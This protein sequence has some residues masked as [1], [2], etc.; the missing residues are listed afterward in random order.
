MKNIVPKENCLTEAQL[1]RYLR[2]ECSA[3][4]VRAIDRHLTHCPMCSDALEGA[5]LLSA[6]RLERSLKHL[7]TKISM[8]FSEKTP[9]VDAQKPV[10]TVVKSP[11][12][13]GWL[14]AAASIAV[15]V[16]AGVMLLTK[17]VE[18][19]FGSSVVVNNDTV[20][21]YQSESPQVSAAAPQSDVAQVG[22]SEK[23][24]K[25]GID[26]A[27]S[28]GKSPVSIENNVAVTEKSDARVAAEQS[29]LPNATTT[30]L[31]QADE[32]LAA[33]K[34][35]AT[36]P[37]N[38]D[39][40][41]ESISAKEAIENQRM[42]TKESATKMQDVAVAD[43]Y[44]K[45][46]NNK[47]KQ[48][49]QVP[50]AAPSTANNYPGAATQ[51][52]MIES[53]NKPMKAKQTTDNGL[54]DYQIGMQFYTKGQYQEATSQLNRVLAKQNSGDVY[55]NALWYLANSYLKLGKKQ[56]AQIL[57]QRIVAEKGKYAQQAQALLK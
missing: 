18:S 50:S 37:A 13:Y 39:T 42:V 28:E 51:N 23:S 21:A 46:S 12:R 31:P 9:I 53:Q 47:D 32:S 4:E 5:I 1:T 29:N 27:Q 43:S 7:D 26:N 20:P 30:N 49:R 8:E 15:L 3:D 2:D 45:A 11:K 57:L 41:G 36:K 35:I 55:Q 44:K 34:P 19:D 48:T 33:Y 54:T 17:P 25:I 24:G 40:E 22:S 52:V 6:P 56:D 16:T 38:L 14:W 10:M